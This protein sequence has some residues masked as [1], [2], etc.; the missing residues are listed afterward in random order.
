[1][2]LAACAAAVAALYATGVGCPILHFLGVRCPGC[3]L[4]RAVL[5]ACRLDARAAFAAHPMVW[6]LP[7][8]F[9]YF[10]KDGRAFR[11]KTVNALVLGGIAAGFLAV[12]ALR[13][14]R[15]LA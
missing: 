5:A 8:L 15:V 11:R 3:G 6:A 12:W 1:L 13:M 9:L 14:A 2:I 10:W 4:T 7:V